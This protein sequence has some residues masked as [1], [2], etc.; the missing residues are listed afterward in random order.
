[1]GQITVNKDKLTK[2]LSTAFDRA[3]EQ[4][5]IDSQYMISDSRWQW[6]RETARSNGEV[7]DSPRDIVDTGNLYDSLTISRQGSKAELIWDIEYATAVHDGA[8]T[9]NG[10]DLPARPWVVET[11]KETTAGKVFGRS[12]IRES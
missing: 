1:M 6:T 3:V 10:V 7:V 11:I 5:V 12:V 9:K 2:V 8:T 4:L